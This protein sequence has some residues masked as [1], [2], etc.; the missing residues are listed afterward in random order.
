MDVVISLLFDSLW[1]AYLA[2]G[3]FAGFL[4]GLLGIGGGA[5]MVPILAMIFAA[6]G[7]PQEHLM[8]LALG[9]SMAVI[10]FTAISSIR[11]HHARGGV[12]WS[13]VR[14]ITPGILF[15]T[16]AG[17][18]V[19]SRI[20]TRELSW[21]F[22]GLVCLIALQ[23]ALNLKPKA[24]RGLPGRAG[25]IA[26][27]S[28]IGCVSA[29]AAI[30]GGAMTMPF[31]TFCNVRVQQAIGTSAAVGLPIALSGTLGYLWNGSH[32]EGLPLGSYGYV[33][34][35]A[36]FWVTTT[37][38]LAAPWGAKLAHKLPVATLKRLFA[39]VLVSLAV[40]LIASLS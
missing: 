25:L 21:F 17:S 5:V 19:V 4:A 37:S 14:D 27:G 28:G 36:L 15:G 6:Q 10:I 22:A 3:L 31:L 24:S 20:P 33:Y 30:G 26:T 34:L 29:L 11:A 40:K 35:P 18:L 9:T 16:F 23:M 8:H 2:L 32:V 7:L 13:V 39:L 12:L 38:M 1:P